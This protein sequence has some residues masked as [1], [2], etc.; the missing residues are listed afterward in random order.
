MR[1]ARW[2]SG[3]ET[4]AGII[5]D[6]RVCP[7]PPGVDLVSLLRQGPDALRA[8]ARAAVA[9]PGRPLS[10]VRLRPPVDPPS[11]RD[12]L[13]FHEHLEGVAARFGHP[14]PPAWHEAPTFYFSNPHSLVGPY[15]D[16]AV[17][18]GCRVFDFEL[19]VAA[20]IGTA[21]RDLTPAQARDHILGYVIMN[22][23]SARDLQAREMTV[24]LGPAKGK[25]SATTVGPWLVTTDELEQ[26][27]DADG[28]LDL[29]MTVDVNGHRVGTDTSANMSWTF[30]ELVAYA[31]RGTWVRPGDLIGSGTCG[32]GCLAELWGR[33]GT[34][35]PPPLRPGDTVTM[36]VTGLGHI[37]NRVV[38]GADA[39][40]LPRARSKP[41]R[42]RAGAR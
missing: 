42:Q 18:P 28:F 26:H 29:E 25:D 16:V 2:R 13:A 40:A 19:E 37:S 23:W 21:G 7:F 35:D 36:A 12:F 8:T 3:A 5:V 32:S 4:H 11:V 38:A 15:D 33:R 17:P 1:F 31:S 14:V 41:V 39:V 10:G 9:A 6:D 30:E 24:Q 34:Q 20:V 27:R 22:D